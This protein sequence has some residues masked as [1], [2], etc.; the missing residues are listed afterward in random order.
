LESALA[1]LPAGGQLDGETAFKLHDT[2]GFPVD[3]TADV[4]RERGMTVDEAG[5]DVAMERQRDQARA[6]GK[7]KMAEGLVYDGGST[8]FHGYET[9]AVPAA[10]VT[11]LYVDGSPVQ[12]VK[13]G[14]AAVVVLDNTPFY[15]QSGGQVGDRGVLQGSSAVFNVSDRQM[16]LVTMVY[17]RRAAW[18]LVRQSGRRWMRV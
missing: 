1:A 5:F 2:Y 16:Y 18:Q 6:A 17:L 10:T 9:L 15:A 13:A 14:Q 11:A 3:L 4:C 8:V 7:F 12:Q